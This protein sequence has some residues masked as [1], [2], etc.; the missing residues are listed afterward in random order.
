MSETVLPPPPSTH[1]H[2]HNGRPAKPLWRG[3]LHLAWFE[4]SL[5]AATVLIVVADSATE[6]VAVSIYGGSLC[7]LFGASALYHRGNWRPRVH[8]NLQRLDHLMIF[9]LIAGTAT[10]VFLLANPGVFGLVLLIVMWSLTLIASSIHQIWMH[11]PDWVVTVAFI[12]LGITAALSVPNLLV[13][14]GVAS[15][16]LVI[17]GAVI[18][19]AGAISFHFHRPDPIPHIFGFHEVFHTC[20]CVAATLQFIAIAFLLNL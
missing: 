10:P 11:A 16:V 13:N 14:G 15:M 3:W 19:V 1:G 4:M 20:V 17:A 12:G 8:R 18:Y 5:V 2:A 6:I 7:G 9:V